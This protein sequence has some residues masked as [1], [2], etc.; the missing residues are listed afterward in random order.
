MSNITDKN[1]KSNNSED[2]RNKQIEEMAQIIGECCYKSCAD[3]PLLSDII[4]TEVDEICSANV[5]SCMACKVAR[6]LTNAGY[7]KQNEVIDEFSEKLKIRCGCI[8]QQHFTYAEVE[9]WIDQVAKEMK[10]GE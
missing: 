7:R 4:P 9:F 5:P 6:I 8:P 3:T 1:F 2:M 10:G